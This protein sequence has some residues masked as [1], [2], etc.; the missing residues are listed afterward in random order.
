MFRAIR[1][2][3]KIVSGIGELIVVDYRD[4]V[5]PQVFLYVKNQEALLLLLRL[6][7]D[8]SRILCQTLCDLTAVDW[9]GYKLPSSYGVVLNQGRFQLLYN[10]V[11]YYFNFR[12]NVS[13][14]IA[15]WV[16]VC[17]VG[18][19][20]RSAVWLERELWDMFGIFFIGHVDLRRILTDYGF[21][22]FPLRKDFPLS[23]YEELRYDEATKGI[24]Y[25]SLE[26]AQ[27][28]RPNDSLNPWASRILDSRSK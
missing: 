7:K 15:D 17:S 12:I 5:R 16:N 21:A 27:E 22:G 8:H 11:S 24:A 10:L 4:F 9:L 26:L 25:E 14:F 6:L 20:F 2:L 3:S 19:L 23:G 28:M 1:L 18:S 13:I